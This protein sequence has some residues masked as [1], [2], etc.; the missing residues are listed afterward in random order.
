MLLSEESQKS[1]HKHFTTK[2]TKTTCQCESEVLFLLGDSRPGNQKI[3][4]QKGRPR[5]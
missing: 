3:E 5:Y 1:I 2:W 4:E